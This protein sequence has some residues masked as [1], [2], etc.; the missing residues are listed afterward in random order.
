MI[1]EQSNN[2]KYIRNILIL[3]ILIIGSTFFSKIFKSKTTKALWTSTWTTHN[4]DELGIHLNLPVNLDRVKTDN[5]LNPAYGFESRH[6][7]ISL[8]TLSFE[9]EQDVTTSEIANRLLD[10]FSSLM[11]FTSSNLKEDKSQSN[12]LISVITGSVSFD[13]QEY[14]LTH[15]CAKKDATYYIIIIY[16]KHGDEYGKKI[17][18]RIISTAQI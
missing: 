12:G 16:Y 11:N 3:L 1:N 2:K 15:F 13:N 8:N 14:D 6:L 4:F 5:K 10:K 7:A 17:K 9:N 18:D